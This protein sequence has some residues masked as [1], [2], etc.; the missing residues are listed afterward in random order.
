MLLIF[1]Y[2]RQLTIRVIHRTLYNA[3]LEEAIPSPTPGKAVCDSSLNAW[4]S[5]DISLSLAFSQ[6]VHI[7]GSLYASLLQRSQVIN[8]PWRRRW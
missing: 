7:N 6:P 2:E 8:N 5:A 3:H 4:E 1:H